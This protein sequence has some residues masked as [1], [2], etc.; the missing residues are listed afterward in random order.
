MTNVSDIGDEYKMGAR[1]V[2]SD[3]INF[4]RLIFL[5]SDCQTK[6]LSIFNIKIS[7]TCSDCKS[8]SCKMLIISLPS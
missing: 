6:H 1:L 7:D 4:L 2:A 8:Q 5:G 3:F